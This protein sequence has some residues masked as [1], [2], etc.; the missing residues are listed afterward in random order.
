VIT[1]RIKEQLKAD[2][3]IAT[4]MD[5]KTGKVIA[6]ASSNRFNPSRIQREDYPSLN[7]NAIEYSY[8]PGFGHQTDH[9]RPPPRSRTH[10]SL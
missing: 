7:T 6:L 10:Q 5:A 2:E 3:I 1:D 9:F 8:E 4:V